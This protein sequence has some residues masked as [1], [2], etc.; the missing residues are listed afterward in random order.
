MIV[1]Y[2]NNTNVISLNS[3]VPNNIIEKAKSVSI[4]GFLFLAA[5]QFPNDLLVW[6]H[7]SLK[8]QLNIS[9]IEELFHHQK[10][11]CSFNPSE[12]Y[13]PAM[14]GYVEDTPFIKI[15]KEVQYPT[16]QMSGW[17]GGIHASVINALAP[18]LK[19]ENDFTYF[20]SSLA[21]KA[22][23]LG[24]L[25]YSNPLLLKEKVMVK[26]QQSSVNSVYKFVKQHYK[27]RWVFLLLLNRL[28]YERKWD[29]I[30]FIISLFYRK[31]SFYSE[32]LDQ[33]N[34]NSS[35]KLPNETNLD[36]IIPTIGRKDYLYDVLKDLSKQTKL[37]KN[38]I[39]IEQNPNP[40]S[41][42]ELDYLTTESWPFTIKYQLINKT[43]ACHARNLALHQ[44]ASEWVFLADDDIRMEP[45]FLEKAFQ[46]ISKLGSENYTFS[47]LQEGEKSPNK[48]IIQWGTFGSGCSI[49]KWN[50]QYQ[51]L[52]NEAYEFGYGEDADFGMQLRNIGQDVLYVPDPSI[53]HLKAPMGGF[54]TKPTLAWQKDKIQPKPSP[55]V[56]L[57]KL[58]HQTEQ[59]LKGYKTI[60]FFKYYRQQS[61]KNPV[62]YYL[63][64]QQQWKQSIRWAH[65]LRKQI[66]S[67]HILLSSQNILLCHPD[68]Q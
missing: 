12:G 64:F 32:A 23:P 4:G 63:N 48:R 21:K 11:M 46:K 28:K 34:V 31:S 1:L 55:T 62:K 19:N 51:L 44:V 25:C 61:I 3:D 60:L 7:I 56:M 6:C 29:V 43:G 13:W 10:I 53:M 59:Q 35:R 15:N 33:I 67:K 58:L 42:S 27:S 54:R 57:F 37:P 16:W 36:V 9:R 39:I 22:M 2:H 14:V 17:V 50:S 5:K 45:A 30:P 24:L 52:F 65:E 18:H 26:Q 8:E 38:V 47:C 20:L 49:I 41:M 40:D 68:T 66:N